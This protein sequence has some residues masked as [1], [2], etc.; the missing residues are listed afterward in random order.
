MKEILNVVCW[1]RE[2]EATYLWGSALVFGG[3]DKY[4]QYNVVDMH[5]MQGMR[6][7]LYTD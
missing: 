1:A 7:S 5:C 2:R 4:S 3:A 6:L